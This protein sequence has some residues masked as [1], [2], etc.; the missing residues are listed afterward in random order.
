MGLLDI[1]KAGKI[2]TENETLKQQILML[3]QQL[4]DTQNNYNE[5]QKFLIE[6]YGTDVLLQ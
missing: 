4:N 1:F 3:N 6:K 5:L 2:K